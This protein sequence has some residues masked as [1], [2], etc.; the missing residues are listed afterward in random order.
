MSRASLLALAA[1]SAIACSDP[2]EFRPAKGV[3]DLPSQKTAYRVQE[4]TGDCLRIGFVVRARAIEDIAETVA[5]H[6]GTHFKVV[7]DRSH[8]TTETDFVA[9]QSFGVVHGSSSSY[10]V[11]H[12]RYTAEAYR[13]AD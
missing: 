10:D 7:D 5:N 6:G 11:K 2:A 12:H 4:S 8:V 1:L 9:R 3:K 13:C